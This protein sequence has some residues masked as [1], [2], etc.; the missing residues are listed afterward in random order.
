MKGRLIYIYIYIYVCVCIYIYIYIYVCVCVDV[1]CY[2]IF[3]VAVDDNLSS[4]YL[5]FS[6]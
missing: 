2:Y 6:L 5:K 1:R 3:S 4:W